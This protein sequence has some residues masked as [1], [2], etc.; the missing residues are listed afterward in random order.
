MNLPFQCPLGI[1]ELLDCHLSGAFHLH[2]VGLNHRLVD[3][4]MQ[5]QRHLTPRAE[6]FLRVGA[7]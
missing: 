1:S 5:Q 6:I 4:E 3:I 7:E 2:A